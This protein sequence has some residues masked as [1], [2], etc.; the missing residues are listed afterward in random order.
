MPPILERLPGPLRSEYPPFLDSAC[1][2][3]PQ[4]REWDVVERDVHWLLIFRSGDI[5]HASL[6]VYHVP[7]QPVL[8]PSSQSCVHGDLELRQMPRVLRTYD[9]SQTLVLFVGEKP[10][11][12]VVFAPMA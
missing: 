1:A 5:Q 12:A 10:H 11:A 4:Y 8:A 9:I 2:N 3:R 6:P 7:C